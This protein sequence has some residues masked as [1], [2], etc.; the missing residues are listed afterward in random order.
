MILKR[1]KPG[2]VRY[3]RSMYKALFLILFLT[4]W[5]AHA[6]VFNFSD[7]SLSVFFGGSVGYSDLY[8]GA[9][10]D[11]SGTQTTAFSDG[12]TYNQSVELGASLKIRTVTFKFGAEVLQTNSLRDVNGDNAS[13]TKLMTLDS[14]VFVFNPNM[15]VEVDLQQD[16]LSRSFIGLGVGLAEVDVDNTY[17][18]TTDGQTAYPAVSDYIDETGGSTISYSIHF[19]QEMHFTDNV[20]FLYNLG[21]RFMNFDSLEYDKAVTNFQGS[22]AKGSTAKFNDGTDRTIDMSS[23]FLGISFRFYMSRP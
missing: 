6:R 13:G 15:V 4:S 7:E 12:V 19:G 21:Y 2:T 18:L 5:S 1:S 17:Q 22:A 16:S 14:K 11:S 9:F 23:L 20:T 8:Q 10:K 3:N